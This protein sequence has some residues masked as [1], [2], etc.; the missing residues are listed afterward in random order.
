MKD[1]VRGGGGGRGRVNQ[2][3]QIVFVTRENGADRVKQ[4]YKI[5]SV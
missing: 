5:V 1:G 2:N 3:K 4:K